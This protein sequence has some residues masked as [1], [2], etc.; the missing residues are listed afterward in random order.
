MQYAAHDGAASPTPASTPLSSA[1]T[2][3]STP[4]SSGVT[5]PPELELLHAA[6]APPVSVAAAAM[7]TTTGGGR[8]S[9]FP[10]G[11]GEAAHHA[12]PMGRIARRA[13]LPAAP[14]M[15]GAPLAVALLRARRARR[16]NLRRLRRLRVDAR[17]GQLGHRVR[18][19][20]EHR[21]RRG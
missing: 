1:A 2:N 19:W 4:A 7:A 13:R 14:F 8:M 21:R 20:L 5:A 16:A 11:V 6:S 9:L 3:P 18:R 15:A 17:V 10:P 12:R